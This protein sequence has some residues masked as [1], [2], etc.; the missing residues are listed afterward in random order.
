VKNTKKSTC[1]QLIS[2]SIEKAQ[3]LIDECEFNVVKTAQSPSSASSLLDIENLIKHIST[4]QNSMI[5]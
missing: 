4:N 3:K 5:H 1:I 2:E